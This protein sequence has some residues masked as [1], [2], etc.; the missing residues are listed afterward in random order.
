MP[1]NAVEPN[2][3]S[4]P[5]LSDQGRQANDIKV[6]PDRAAGS[7]PGC[8]KREVEFFSDGREPGS[9]PGHANRRLFLTT[10][11]SKMDLCWI[12]PDTCRI[13]RQWLTTEPRRRKVVAD[14]SRERGGFGSFF[15]VIGEETCFFPYSLPTTTTCYCCCCCCCYY[16]YY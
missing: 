8:V 2:P 3:E 15:L 13:E 16:Y 7:I 1:Q 6:G 12:E 11:N 9:N 5:G 14:R 10:Q 4:N